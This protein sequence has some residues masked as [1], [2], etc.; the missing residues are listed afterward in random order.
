MIFNKRIRELIDSNLGIKNDLLSLKKENE[1][2]KQKVENLSNIVKKHKAET[3]NSTF[4]FDF[5][6][7]DVFSIERN[8]NNNKQCTIIGFKLTKEV[9]EN[10]KLVITEELK[11]WY[12]YCPAEQHEKLVEEFNRFNKGKINGTL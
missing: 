12:F 1:D 10:D 5:A 4:A 3:Q 7:V 9:T 2:L 8:Y 11:E 6:K